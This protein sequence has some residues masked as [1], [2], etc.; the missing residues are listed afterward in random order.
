M[1]QIAIIARAA[2][3]FMKMQ[4]E[5]MHAKQPGKEQLIPVWVPPPSTQYQLITGKCVNVPENR[6]IEITVDEFLPL[7]AGGAR[8]LNRN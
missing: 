5:Q 7:R 3:K 6:I 8:R 2:L 4:V 1:P